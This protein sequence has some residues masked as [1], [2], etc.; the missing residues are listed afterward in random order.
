MSSSTTLKHFRVGQLVTTVAGPRLGTVVRI[1]KAHSILTKGQFVDIRW[2]VGGEVDTLDESI[3][4]PSA[5]VETA[6]PRELPPNAER[7]GGWFG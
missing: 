1:R 6:L 5:S 3:L 2:K 4:L 7:C